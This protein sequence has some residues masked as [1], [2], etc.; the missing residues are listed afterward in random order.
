MLGRDKSTSPD[1]PYRHTN[2]TNMNNCPVMEWGGVDFNRK[3][4]GA[5]QG[6]PVINSSPMLPTG[7]RGK[8]F[9]RCPLFWIMCIFRGSKKVTKKL[10]QKLQKSYNNII[11]KSR[12]WVLQ[13][14]CYL[15][16]AAN[17]SKTFFSPWKQAHQISCTKLNEKKVFE[18][19]NCWQS[20]DIM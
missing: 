19:K 6:T 13:N 14:N 15:W 12:N 7:G 8:C 1:P 9:C 16:N 4:W 5:P 2:V 3:S 10:Q 17:S 18:G 20:W 11:R